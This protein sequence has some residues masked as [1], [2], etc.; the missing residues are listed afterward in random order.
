MKTAGALA[1]AL[2]AVLGVPSAADAA[3]TLRV[4]RPSARGFAGVPL[5]TGV[6]HG[7]FARH[8]LALELAVFGGG[9]TSQAMTAGSVDIS[10]QSGTEMAFLAKGVPA[11]AVAALAGPPNELVLVVGPD[12]PLASAADLKGRT[13][14]VTGPSLTGWLV[15]AVSQ[16]QGWGPQGIKMNYAQPAASWALL[17]TRKIDGMV[18]DLGTALQAERDGHARILL[19]FGNTLNDFHVFVAVAHN[20]LIGNKPDA[21]RRFLA[22]WFETIAFMRANKAATVAVSVELQEIGADIASRV[23]DDVMAEFSADG[24]FSDKALAVLARSFVELKY[25][26]SEPDMKALYTEEFL[27]NR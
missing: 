22:A 26:P 6:K 1:V 19:R 17:K 11:K 13:I 18:V 10:V 14:G 20:D 4:G 24:R 5:V 15:S 3:D 27:P 7:V 21:V 8:G 23:Y 12:L 16:Q 25:L 9:R 2:V